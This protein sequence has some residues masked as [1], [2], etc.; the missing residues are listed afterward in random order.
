MMQKHLTGTPVYYWISGAETAESILFVH[1][2][3]ADHT[4]FD[5]QADYFSKH[6][7]VI[8][9]DLIGHGKST[10]TQKGDGIEKTSDYI[11]Q[12]LDAE[13]IG[14]AHLVGVSIGAVLIQ[15]FAN[16]FPDRVASLCCIGGYDINRFPASI[17]KENGGAQLR[18]M[19]KALFSI[20][21]FAR[22][23]KM[24]SAA[25]PEAQER[26][27]R[28]NLRFKR[29]SFRYLAGLSGLINRHEPAPRHYPLMIG[30]GEKDIP[31]AIRAANMWHAS[32]PESKLVVFENAGHL[33]NMDVPDKFNEITHA[34]L[35]GKL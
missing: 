30:Y 6:Y 11:R 19:L 5:D 1:A 33:A 2:A 20:E 29:S 12:L 9:L 21:W 35:T 16:K 25:T 3:F 17:Q 34:F 14:K 18:M 15:D 28:M 32:E 27:Y 13:E 10:V 22:S 8:A 24:I 4:S 7:R 26:F 31:L 23:N